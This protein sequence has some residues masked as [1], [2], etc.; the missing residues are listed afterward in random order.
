MASMCTTSATSK[1]RRLGRLAQILV[2]YEM[3]GS[4]HTITPLANYVIKTFGS[5]LPDLTPMKL[6]KVLFYLKAWGLV[7]G[8]DAVTGEFERWKFGPVNPGLYHDLKIF[9][10]TQA[11]VVANIPAEE[12]KGS[13][14]ELLEVVMWTYGQKSAFDLSVLSHG[15]DPWMNTP[16]SQ[17]ITD[18]VILAYYSKQPF[19]KVVRGFD[20]T[21]PFIPPMSSVDAA[22]MLEMDASTRK[23]IET[24]PSFHVYRELVEDA[25]KSMAPKIAAQMKWFHDLPSRS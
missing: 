10:N 13:V 22:F 24:Y 19:A 3:V 7:A 20:K 6:Q 8:V 17:V 9:R 4:A 23:A 2:S 25:R 21:K 1:S 11:Q 12:P 15:E 18:D 5:D 14:L 16:D